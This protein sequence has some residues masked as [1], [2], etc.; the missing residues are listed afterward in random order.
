ML[1][2]FAQAQHWA[3]CFPIFYTASRGGKTKLRWD[4]CKPR[5]WLAPLA[6]DTA[7]PLNSRT[8]SL[9]T[10]FPRTPT[11]TTSCWFRRICFGMFLFSATFSLSLLITLLS[12]LSPSA[13]LSKLL[14]LQ[15]LLLIFVETS[16]CRILYPS[17][18]FSLQT[19]WYHCHFFF[20][21]TLG[22]E[23]FWW[24]SHRFPVFD[25]YF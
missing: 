18:S 13:S 6:H 25:A 11:L 14:D 4:T 5:A 7:T 3:V 8:N 23:W 12:F 20:F 9:N 16:H 2:S 10:H 1:S 17:L 21:Y 15:L 24:L 22:W 19:Q